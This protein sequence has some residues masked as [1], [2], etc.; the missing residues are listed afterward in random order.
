[1]W[2]LIVALCTLEGLAGCGMGPATARGEAVVA[3]ISYTVIAAF[4]RLVEG[5]PK[6]S[7]PIETF[8]GFSAAPDKHIVF[9][10]VQTLAS[11]LGA[12]CARTQETILSGS[13]EKVGFERVTWLTVHG[14]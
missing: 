14:I 12:R 13:D 2:G 6:P 5:K 7:V 1:M 8:D 4:A 10:F 9:L 3:L 11:W